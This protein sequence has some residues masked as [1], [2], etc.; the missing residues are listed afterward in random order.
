MSCIVFL[1]LLDQ[2]KVKWSWF[3][4]FW[5]RSWWLLKLKKEMSKVAMHMP[6]KH[7]GV[8]RINGPLR[9]TVAMLFMATLME[10]NVICKN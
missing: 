8:E 5:L 3:S 10:T 2:F 6:P 7:A 9:E 1:C 4:L